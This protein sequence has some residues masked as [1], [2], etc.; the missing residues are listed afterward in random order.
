MY[1]LDMAAHFAFQFLLLLGLKLV[2][3][4][5]YRLGIFLKFIRLVITFSTTSTCLPPDLAAGVGAGLQGGTLLLKALGILRLSL[6]S[7]IK[8]Y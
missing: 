4:C 5:L 2:Q 7:G 6:V 3:F 1:H 8:H